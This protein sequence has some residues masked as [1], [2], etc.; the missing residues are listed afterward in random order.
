MLGTIDG[1]SQTAVPSISQS[2][3]QLQKS[4]KQLF[5]RPDYFI[6]T[7]STK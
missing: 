1:L 3:Q 4:V 6:A 5:D 2:V 7:Q